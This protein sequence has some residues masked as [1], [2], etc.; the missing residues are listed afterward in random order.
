M[1][2]DLYINYESGVRMGIGSL[3]ARSAYEAAFRIIRRFR[4]VKSVEIERQ[5]MIFKMIAREYPG[6]RYIVIYRQDG[7]IVSAWALNGEIKDD[8]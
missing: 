1:K 6:G 8:H 7:S 5:D 3:S 2:G 4:F